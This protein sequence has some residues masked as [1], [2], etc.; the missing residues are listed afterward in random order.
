MSSPAPAPQDIQQFTDALQVTLD[1]Y[2]LLVERLAV[3]E[4]QLREPGW[5]RIG[6][7][8]RDFSREGLRNI[9]RMARI[10][11]LKNPLIKRAVAVQNLYVWGQGVTLRAVHPTVDAVIQKVLKD[12]TNRTVFGDVE[13]W[14]RLETGLQLFANLFFVFF[15]NPSTGHVKIRTIPFDEIAAVISNPD[16][17]Q[18]P[19]YYL[20]VWN[21]TTVNPSTGFPTVE[22]KKAYYPDWRYN[23][24]GGHPTHIAGIPVKES[25][26][27]HVSVNRLDDMQFGVSE[28]YAACDWA[29]AYKTFLEKWVTITDALSK[30]AMQLTGAN[31]RAA[32]AAVSKLQEMIPRLQQGL[33][34]ARASTGGTIGG[35][36]VTTPGTKLEPIKTSG[37]TTSMDDARR[38]M[39][40]VCSATGIN[41]PYL[42]GDP[43]TGNLATAKSMERPM[44]LQFTARQSLWSSILG[45]ILDYIIDQAAMMPSGPLQAGATVEIDDDGDRLVTLGADP[46]TGEPMNRT[47]EVRFP[48]IL[49]RDLTE[50]VDAIIHAGTLKGAAAAGTIPVKHLTRMLLDVLGEEHAADLVEEWFPEGETPTDSEAALARAIGRLETYL[51]EVTGA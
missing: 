5:Q 43:S 47:I 12:P 30:F 37:I 25:P 28:L 45:N 42:T 19:W 39:L 44:E 32:T 7:G 9:S 34:E 21:T 38:L 26:I 16:D 41:E 33:A 23:P 36:F 48:S 27:Y 14:M 8:E 6:G 13:A 51:T 15:V 46:E 29:N 1:S 18:D 50:Q 4:D 11:W 40:M 2:D 35:T 22:P 17:A 31:K 3:L 20:R 10:Y 49:K 24:R